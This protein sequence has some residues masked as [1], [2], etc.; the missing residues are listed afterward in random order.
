MDWNFLLRPATTYTEKFVKGIVMTITILTTCWIGLAI[1]VPKITG[2]I[3]VGG[4]LVIAGV[5]VFVGQLIAW[6]G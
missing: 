6:D 3:F 4:L 5:S 2:T 1:L